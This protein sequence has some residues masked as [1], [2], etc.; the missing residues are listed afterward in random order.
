M[1]QDKDF[2][3]LIE[4]APLTKPLDK[5]KRGRNITISHPN[6]LDTRMKEQFAGCRNIDE[7]KEEIS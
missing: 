3:Q 5:P 4:D 1:N 6:Y 7:P 2:R